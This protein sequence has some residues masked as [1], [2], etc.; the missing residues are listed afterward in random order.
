M[1]SPNHI[2][3][4]ALDVDG[5]LTDGRIA[6]DPVTKKEIKFFHVH[7]GLGISL[8]QQAG[9]H[10]ILI[11]GRDSDCVEIRATELQIPFVFQA[12]K[13]KVKDLEDALSSIGCSMEQTCFIGDDLGGVTIM[14]QVGYSIAVQNATDEVKHNSDWQT[15]RTGGN[16]AVREAIEHLMKANG[17]W[18]E[19][20]RT[21]QSEHVTQ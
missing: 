3:V 10:T 12:S 20:V 1:K 14:S 21:I 16:G 2:S 15:K 11:S 19:Q 9:N 13:D 17:T 6:F 8:W 4:L 18:E 5:V 7:D